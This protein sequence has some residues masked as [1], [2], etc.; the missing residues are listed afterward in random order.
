MLQTDVDIKV[1]ATHFTHASTSYVRINMV[2]AK[3]QKRLIWNTSFFRQ[4]MA[5][6]PSQ[7]DKQM[8]NTV[9]ESQ[10]VMWEAH[11]RT[12]LYAELNLYVHEE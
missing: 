8:D 1:V 2:D 10:L 7:A 3:S 4:V 6:E 9:C 5:P 12:N 11:G